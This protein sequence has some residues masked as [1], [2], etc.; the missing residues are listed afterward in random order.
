MPDLIGDL[1]AETMKIALIGV[2][3]LKNL[4]EEAH[5][6]P[7]EAQ[8]KEAYGDAVWGNGAV[9]RV[10]FVCESPGVVCGGAAGCGD[11]VGGGTEAVFKSR[12]VGMMDGSACI[13]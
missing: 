10:F 5:V 12:S 13:G 2:T 8:L 7:M 4:G 6:Q 9:D 11:G 3:R 1:N